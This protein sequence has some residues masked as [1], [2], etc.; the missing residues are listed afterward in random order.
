MLHFCTLFPLQKHILQSSCR[1]R[2]VHVCEDCSKQFVTRKHDDRKVRCQSAGP[3]RT[4]SAI[5]SKTDEIRASV[6][7]N[8]KPKP[9]R[10]RS[11]FPFS[12]HKKSN[13][14]IKPKGPGPRTRKLAQAKQEPD[15]KRVEDILYQLGLSLK[16]DYGTL[17]VR[18]VLAP[19]FESPTAVVYDLVQLQR[20]F[21]K[22]NLPFNLRE[23]S[24]M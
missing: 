21:Q 18:T 1:Y 4:S 2:F 17:S 15:I 5:G 22:A 12:Y 13:V 7:V 10:P 3:L 6:V 14:E 16:R 20:L 24:F 19:S 23:V 8:T 11:A 9:S